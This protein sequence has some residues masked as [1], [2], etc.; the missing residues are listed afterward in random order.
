MDQRPRVMVLAGKLTDASKV[1]A[2]LGG[3]FQIEMFT[4]HAEAMKALR[5]GRM[6]H[7]IYADVGDY[8]PLERALVDQ[9]AK[10]VLD[11]I[12]EGVC[13]V[14]DEGRCVWANKRMQG[15]P[16]DVAA[17]VLD[18]CNSAGVLFGAQS[19]TPASSDARARSKKF[20]FQ[21]G[22][23]R[24]FEMFVSPVFNDSG[25]VKQLVAVVWDASSGKR[26]QQKIDAIDAAGR[27]LVQ[28]EGQSLCKLSV[29][30]RL[31]LLQDKI[32]SFTSELMHFDHFIIRLLEKKTNKLEPV[33]SVGLPEDALGY[34]LY[35][36]PEG[37]GISGYVASTGRSYICHDVERDPRYVPGLRSAMS[38][39]TVPLK[40][41]DKVIGIFNIESQ[42]HGAFNEDD[43]QFAEIFG[44][45]IAVALNILDLLKDERVEIFGQLSDAVLQELSGPLND[46]TTETESLKE[47][48]IGHDDMRRRLDRISEH[49]NQLRASIKNLSRGPQMVLGADKHRTEHDPMLAGKRVLVADDE[50]TIRS[51]VAAVLTKLGCQVTICEDGQQA[52]HFLEHNPL[53]MIVS[54][55]RLPHKNGY[56]IFAAAQ[57]INRSLPVVLMTGFGYDPHHSIVRASQDGLQAVLFKP[58]RVEQLVAEVHKALKNA[59]P[60][61]RPGGSS[62]PTAG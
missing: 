3:D 23:D 18:T 39:L 6:F 53:D 40:L 25:R 52:V 44:R 4:D 10:V 41:H 17:K 14:D 61:S 11:T 50:E 46:I 38:S 42:R 2:A 12:G 28:L 54:D 37:N 22:N 62:H 33:I 35:A 27:A 16:G 13:V 29:A 56:E 19:N 55:I 24:Y 9:Q 30:E 57:K 47:E 48:Y 26:L 7:G 59:A 43:R 1:Q 15:F 31:K 36:Q 51:T 20:G 8:L 34:D 45:Y 32:I 60:A 5:S 58:F 21:I 49:V